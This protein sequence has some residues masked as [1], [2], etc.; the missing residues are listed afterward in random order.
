MSDPSRAIALYG[1]D[2]TVPPP[3]ILRAGKLSAELEA[4]NLRYIRW[5]GHEVLRAVSFI[6]RDKDWGTYNPEI[7]G[8]EITEDDGAF[9]VTLHAVAGDGDQS[10]A[11]NARIEGRADG[12]LT[13]HGTGG[14]E[15]GFLT[16]RTGFV[17]LHPIDGIAGAPVTIEHTDGETAES[18]FPEIIDPV[19]PM[20]D[21]RALSHTTPAGLKVRVLMEGDT[22][23]MEDQR[24]WTDA[25][26]KT[27]VRPLARPWPYRIE[28]GELIDQTIT[29]TVTGTAA[30]TETGGAVKLRPGAEVGPLPP[31][32]LGLRPENTA[33]AKAAAGT[34]RAL[35]PAYM[36]LHHDPRAGHDR[37]TLEAML[38]VA[39]ATG[40]TPWL[41]AVIEATDDAGAA[42]EIAALGATAQDLGHPF[43]TV[44]VSPAPDLKCTL[45]GSIWPDAPDAATLY[46]ATRAAFP[47]ARIGGGM[48]SYFTE[49]NRKRPPVDRLDLLS[50]TTSPMVHAGDDRSVIET[51]EAHP[52][53]VKSVAEIAGTTPW[54]V[55]PSAIGIRDNPYGA[56]AKDNPGNI[57]Q[58]M[59]WNDP[60]QRGLFGAAWALTY[61]A[62]F[63]EGGASSIALG[64]AT[65]PFGAIAAPSE[66]PKPWF[67]GAGGV[68]PVF[69]VLRGLARLEGAAMHTLDLP[70][71]GPVAGLAVQTDNGM[72]IW[73]ANVGPEPVEVALADDAEMRV[74][75]LDAGG[76]AAAAA[77]AAIMDDLSPASGALTLDAFAIARIVTGS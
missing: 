45:P 14:T 37:A 43:H 27:Y 46:D 48:F 52:A 19:Q 8:L 50:F 30:T 22:Y 21:L 38:D 3:R 59:N 26:Y 28:P 76:F 73:V 15:D 70:A 56:S 62:H 66:F 29:V 40:A 10:F 51:R 53:I 58:A 39:R 1:T 25:S 16:N 60:R 11:Y 69:H 55:G 54:A 75:R 71:A 67:D 47:E 57:R 36:V 6:V 42:A 32:G 68:Y 24:N 13:Y 74:A 5:D 65:G 9:T 2:E 35:A 63:A 72:E 17:I 4:G 20:M 49:L 12:T 18:L 23:E 7:S 77:N 64:A 44:L 41:E 61:F 34:L 31:L 33:T